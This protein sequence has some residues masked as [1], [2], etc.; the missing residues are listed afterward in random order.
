VAGKS[1]PCMFV[2]K[3]KILARIY[4][5]QSLTTSE[6]DA[7]KENIVANLCDCLN[8][9]E[10]EFG[11]TITVD[12]LNQIILDAD[13]KIKSV[14]IDDL[15]YTTYAKYYY[16]YIR[17]TNIIDTTNNIECGHFITKD[18]YTLTSGICPYCGAV[19]EWPKD[20]D[21]Y[22]PPIYDFTEVAICKKTTDNS[23]D[24]IEDAI[25]NIPVY[26]AD[27]YSSDN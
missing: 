6:K 3:Y 23:T 26:S 24:N 20:D 18:L 9:S 25:S 2:N 17:C 8:S 27:T 21:I 19:I 7:L 1:H 16:S 4:C 11:E 22:N 10:I 14:N 13:S 5:K 12:R 15:D